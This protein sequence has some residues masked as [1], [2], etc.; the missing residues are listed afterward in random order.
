MNACAS[1]LQ[2]GTWESIVQL[3]SQLERLVMSRP[4]LIVD[5]KT[6]RRKML[7]EL[8]ES[9][10]EPA[11]VLD[12]AEDVLEAAEGAHL[13][14]VAADELGPDCAE[15][16]EKLKEKFPQ[17]EI[18]V[19]SGFGCG[20][21]TLEA[22][23]AGVSDVMDPD[24]ETREMLLAALD[25]ALGRSL[26]TLSEKAFIEKLWEYNEAFLKKMVILEKRNFQLEERLAEEIR[27][28]DDYGDDR[29][30]KRVLI[31]EDEED[32]SVFMRDFLRSKGYEVDTA[33]DAPLGLKKFRAAPPDILVTDKNLP[34][35]T[36]IELVQAIRKEHPGVPVIMVT[37][38]ASM[39]S[40]IK[41]LEL[42]ICSYMQKPF[43]TRDL[44]ANIEEAL[45]RKQ[46]DIRA[47][48]Y[49]MRFKERNEE[50]LSA[51]K[52]IRDILQNRLIEGGTPVGD[53]CWKDHRS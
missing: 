24:I 30:P 17:I 26:G 8:V 14:L 18:L 50:F 13:A 45:G 46:E 43:R 29:S 41:A 38:Y 2:G 9:A 7:A 35:M 19:V 21:D 47:K 39:E 37:G 25:R 23:H 33:A 36:G 15:L 22:V 40:A 34:G 51:F 5:P 52:S 44:V 49:L 42:G 11:V 4:V 20:I 48:R 12:S 32:V 10:G 31:V 1:L 16:V 28:D 53:Q 6:D 3:Y 27:G